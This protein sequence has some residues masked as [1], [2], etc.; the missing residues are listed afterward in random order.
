MLKNT[1]VATAWDNLI[2][3][4]KVDAVRCSVLFAWSTNSHNSISGIVRILLARL[5][6]SDL[7]FI[8]DRKVESMGLKR[9]ING[10]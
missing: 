9:A 2:F 4:R 3:E 8:T 7:S 5:L 6:T 10:K 1:F